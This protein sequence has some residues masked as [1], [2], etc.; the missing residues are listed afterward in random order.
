MAGCLH[1][2]SRCATVQLPYLRYSMPPMPSADFCHTVRANYSSL[3]HAISRKRLAMAYGRPS[4]VRT[5]PFDAQTPDLYSTSR[6]RMEDFAVT[7]PLVPDVPHLVSGS[8]SSPRIFGLGFLQ[9]QPRACALAL[10]LT[11]GSANSWCGD[12]HPTNYG[13]CP[14][15]TPKLTGA[16]RHPVQR[17]VRRRHRYRQ[18]HSC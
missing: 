17:L 3:S 16:V 1:L 11:L 6:L 13:P 4:G 5:V 7:C 12:F 18:G 15:H 9:T 14:A 10:L 8:C 2:V